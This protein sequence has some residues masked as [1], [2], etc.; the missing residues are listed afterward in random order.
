[1]RSDPPPGTEDAAAAHL[2]VYAAGAWPTRRGLEAL[3][4]LLRRAAE[5]DRNGALSE[6]PDAAV[7]RQGADT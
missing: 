3:V 5:R 1:M 7:V 6:A 4:R 2:D